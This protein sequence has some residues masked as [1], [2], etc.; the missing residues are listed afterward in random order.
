MGRKKGTPNKDTS[1]LIERA[2]QLKIDPFEIMLFFAANDWKR[3]GYD[4]PTMVK[5]TRD[6]SPYEVD[7]IS[8]ELR[9][10]SAAD[11][12]QYLYPKRKAIEV[13]KPFDPTEADRPLAEISDEQ[14]DEL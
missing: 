5:Y 13:K 12:S 3:L 14:L 8:P 6:G 1:S 9:Q 10:K 11:A 7:R 4:G 2:A